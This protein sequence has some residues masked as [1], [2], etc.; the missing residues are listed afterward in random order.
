MANR[1]SSGV[2]RRR[3]SDENRTHSYPK[4]SGRKAGDALDRLPPA[5]MGRPTT[6]ARVAGQERLRGEP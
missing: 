3:P 2:E 1:D 4:H 5:Q 6:D